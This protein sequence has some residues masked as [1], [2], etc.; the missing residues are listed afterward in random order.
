MARLPQDPG[1]SRSRPLNGQSGGNAS[2]HASSVTEEREA[3][4]NALIAEGEG[5]GKSPQAVIDEIHSAAEIEAGASDDRALGRVGQRFDHRSPF[6]VGMT[7]ALGV[8]VVFVVGSIVLAV[9]QILLLIA[10]AIVI[11]VGLDPAV[12]WFTR[13]G[14]PRWAAVTLVLALALAVF[15]GFLALAIPVLADQATTLA[16]ELPRY[17]H[18]LNNHH[19][20]LGKLN[21]HY[22]VV[23]AIQKFLSKGGSSAIAGCPLGRSGNSDNGRTRRKARERS[24]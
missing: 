22:H 15:G 24:L 16:N 21:A 19:T 13:R 12:A 1:V 5:N 9:G 18:S 14:M 11:A 7:G 17:L 3:G 20:F 23:E 10:M 8:A 4:L 2:S 6:Y